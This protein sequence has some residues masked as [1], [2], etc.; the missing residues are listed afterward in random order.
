MQN[1]VRVLGDNTAQISPAIPFHHSRRRGVG[2]GNSL[3]LKHAQFFKNLL[4][5][6]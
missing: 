1:K 4:S 5:K 3:I 6:S 2:G